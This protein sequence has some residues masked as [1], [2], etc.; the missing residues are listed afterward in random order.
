[1]AGVTALGVIVIGP[2]AHHAARHSIPAWVWLVDVGLVVACFFAGGDELAK[3]LVGE[4]KY[5]R[6]VTVGKKQRRWQVIRARYGHQLIR[7]GVIT[8]MLTLWICVKH[9]GGPL[10][11]PFAPMLAAPAIF[12]AFVAGTVR[13]ILWLLIGASVAIGVFD[14][15]SQGVTG[16]DPY[17]YFLP[18]LSLLLAAVGI[19]MAQ[20]RHDEGL[21]A[22]RRTAV[23]FSNFGDDELK[24]LGEAVLS[25]VREIGSRIDDGSDR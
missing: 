17:A 12:G 11:S 21:R 15:S 25:D 19:S 20:L 14:W 1:M 6:Q 3:I 10:D 4:D 22:V 13:G 8:N 18:Q 24:A 23:A 5:W 7:L 16:S 2:F 9:T